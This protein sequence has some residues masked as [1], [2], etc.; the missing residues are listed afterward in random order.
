MYAKIIAMVKIMKSP[1]DTSQ[2]ASCV[3]HFTLG[4]NLVSDFAQTNPAISLESK[5]EVLNEVSQSEIN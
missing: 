1:P 4:E 2:T 5:H 3:I